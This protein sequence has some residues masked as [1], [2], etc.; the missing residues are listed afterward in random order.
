MLVDFY[1]YISGLGKYAGN[2]FL[3]I[4]KE[5]FVLEQ[6]KELHEDIFSGSFDLHQGQIEYTYVL[7]EEEEY[8]NNI[9]RHI[10]RKHNGNE[11]STDAQ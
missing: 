7:G 2:V 11:S 1:L 5:K 6:R 3:Q 9:I 10:A 8:S 4:H